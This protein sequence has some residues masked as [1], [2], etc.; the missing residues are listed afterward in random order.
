[1]VDEESSD[2]AR[3]FSL[4]PVP[5]S[6]SKER[7]S[8]DASIDDDAENSG[9]PRFVVSITDFDF[10]VPVAAKNRYLRD[11]IVVQIKGETTNALTRHAF[12]E[13]EEPESSPDRERRL[14]LDEPEVWRHVEWL[15]ST[16]EIVLPLPTEL[17]NDGE[18]GDE[19]AEVG[20]LTWTLRIFRIGCADPSAH[21]RC[22]DDDVTTLE[23]L[24][25]QQRA[26]ATVQPQLLATA[27]L[28]VETAIAKR[29]G[30]EIHNKWIHCSLRG[31][32]PHALVR[33]KIKVVCRRVVFP[34]NNNEFNVEVTDV[35]ASL[36]STLLIMLA[37]A[38]TAR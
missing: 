19:F 20:A 4:P 7:R 8:Q 2:T 9:T 12:V 16:G 30:A 26:D 14:A 6:G 13:P 31:H 5:S 15:G 37:T 29:R 3:P 22:G 27:V 21:A 11:P 25:V 36:S 24:R 32:G 28:D 38:L 17:Q 35:A 34:N 10:A 18:V 1:M 23:N 33:G